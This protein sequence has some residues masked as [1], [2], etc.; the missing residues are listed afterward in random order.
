MVFQVPRK[1]LI[2][3]KIVVTSAVEAA[4]PK[5]SKIHPLFLVTAASKPQIIFQ[6]LT[7]CKGCQISLG[8]VWL[9]C[10]F[11]PKQALQPLKCFVLF[12]EQPSFYFSRNTLFQT[13]PVWAHFFEDRKQGQQEDCHWLLTCA[14]IKIILGFSLRVWALLS[15]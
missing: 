14:K 6:T 5:L 9:G 15:P 8:E 10:F 3:R 13:Q 2:P 4:R 12:S 11:L 1:I 7:D